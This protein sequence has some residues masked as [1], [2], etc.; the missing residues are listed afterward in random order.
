[1]RD[2]TYEYWKGGIRR[3]LVRIALRNNGNIGSGRDGGDYSL[4]T[5]FNPT[6]RPS[7]TYLAVHHGGHEATLAGRGCDVAQGQ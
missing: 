2:S 7:R 4:R 5:L 3:A 1:M 6:F